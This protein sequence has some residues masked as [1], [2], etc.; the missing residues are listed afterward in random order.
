MKTILNSIKTTL[1]ATLLAILGTANLAS[2][3]TAAVTS[4]ASLSSTAWAVAAQAAP[5]LGAGAGL[6]V[7][8]EVLA[9]TKAL[10]GAGISIKKSPGGAA[11]TAPVKS[12]ND[13]SFHFS[14]LEAGDY[15][16][17][18]DGGKTVMF[19]VGSDGKLSG[20]AQEGGVVQ[21]KSNMQNLYPCP[22]REN[23][24][25]DN[26]VNSPSAA[27]S[28]TAP[29]SSAYSKNCPIGYTWSGPGE[30]TNAKGVKHSTI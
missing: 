11:R 9:A 28:I 8:G 24:P 27:K 12:A 4:S 19:K 20:L 15:E 25:C 17:T 5:W 14:G 3:P 6:M 7:S 13:G 22:R 1:S 2:L 18:P 29:A 21:T 30:C 26:P 10:P 16:V 23:D